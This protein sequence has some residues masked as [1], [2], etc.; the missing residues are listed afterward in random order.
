MDPTCN[1]S[2]SGSRDQED[3]SSKPAL[4][5]I[6]KKPNHKKELVELLKV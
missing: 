4:T 1:H 6:S 5:P 3:S 2:Y